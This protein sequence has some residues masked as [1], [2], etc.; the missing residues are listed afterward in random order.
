[1]FEAP[2]TIHIIWIGGDIP[3]NRFENVLAI[4]RCQ[5]ENPVWFWAASRWADPR[6]RIPNGFAAIQRRVRGT[7]IV[8]KDVYDEADTVVSNYFLK[9]AGYNTRHTTLQDK[10]CWANFGT[11][12][13][14][15]RYHILHVH[16][17]LYAD[18]DLELKQRTRLSFEDVNQR[19]AASPIGI[20]L[21]NRGKPQNATND[22]IVAPARAPFLGDL[23]A[24]CQRQ[25]DVL[26]RDMSRLLDYESTE[27]GLHSPRSIETMMTTG[28]ESVREFI[29]TAM[30]EQ[31]R[32]NAD[33]FWKTCSIQIPEIDLAGMASGSEQTW[34]K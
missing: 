15:L 1:M 2:L 8:L 27:G 24:H 25:L 22:L 32:A 9:E 30:A 13:D 7:G 14:L 21:H 28:P 4:Q 33:N 29:R 3:K 19:L 18:S 11:A 5:P 20:L 23:I 17:G 6:G 10:A 12:S 34:L 31:V 16:G 26:Y